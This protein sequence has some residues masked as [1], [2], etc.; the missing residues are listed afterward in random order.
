[1][2]KPILVTISN[3]MQCVRLPDQHVYLTQLGDN[4]FRFVMFDCHF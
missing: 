1:M 3:A 2:G 4:F